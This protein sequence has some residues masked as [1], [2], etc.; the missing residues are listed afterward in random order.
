MA[1]M[2]NQEMEG[3]VVNLAEV[4]ARTWDFPKGGAVYLITNLENNKVYIGLDSAPPS[5]LMSHALAKEDTAI[6]RAVRKY[7]AH[8]FVA[9]IL[10]S[11]IEDNERLEL[12]ERAFIAAYN[13]NCCAGGH[14]YN[15]TDGGNGNFGHKQSDETRAKRSKSL[16]GNKNALGSKHSDEQ[17]AAVS[18]RMRG[19]NYALGYKFTD[20]DRARQSAGQ[21]GKRH[22]P[23]RRAA[24]S[25]RMR[26][27]KCWAF[28]KKQSAETRARRSASSRKY[29]AE[30]PRTDEMRARYRAANLGEKNP[31]YGRPKTPEEIAKIRATMKGN[32]RLKLTKGTTWIS[33][34]GKH[35][36]FYPDSDEHKL[37]LAGK[38]CVDIFGKHCEP[39]PALGGQ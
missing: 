21:R 15:M 13:S 18:E 37:A 11:G 38:S 34:N 6:H 30:N 14:G 36:Y 31:A 33:I 24:A 22:S 10:A 4:N 3:R 2:T 35:R 19:N 16:R 1:C 17:R 20:E 32:P 9:Q 27:E 7:G 39:Q 29:F 5:R 28:G 26:G 23:E 25:E 8:M 12:A